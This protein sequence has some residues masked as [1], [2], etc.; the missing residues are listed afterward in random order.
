MGASK[1]ALMSGEDGFTLIEVLVAL[2]LVS[3]LSVGLLTTMRVALSIDV[4]TQRQEQLLQDM[5]IAQRFLRQAIGSAY[6]K[7][8]TDPSVTKRGLDVN[9][10]PKLTSNRRAI[11]T[12]GWAVFS[13]IFHSLGERPAGLP[14]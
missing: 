2:A 11:L 8:D 5:V 12:R 7:L 1:Q 14:R 4:R 10:R 6:P 3:L 13:V 9:R